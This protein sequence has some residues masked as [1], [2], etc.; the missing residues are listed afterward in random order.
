MTF[1]LK[2]KDRRMRYPSSVVP[3]FAAVSKADRSWVGSV[4]TTTPL[5]T[6]K[7]CRAAD[8]EPDLVDQAVEE[9]LRRGLF[10]AEA[11]EHG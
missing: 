2:W 3:S 8:V 4:P 11:L 9:A 6:I 7:D 1:P 5:R 10:R